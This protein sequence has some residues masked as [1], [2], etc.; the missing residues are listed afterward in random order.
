MKKL[1]EEQKKALRQIRWQMPLTV[2]L[3]CF[4]LLLMTQYYTY[5]DKLDSL[6]G[7]SPENLA[8][9]MRSVVDNNGA[10]YAEY[11]QLKTDL[12]KL[13]SDLASGDTLQNT[14]SD[15]ITSLKT[16][17]GWDAVNGE[18]VLVT[19]TSVSNLYYW[20]LIDITNE[21]FNAGAEAVAINS[22]RITIHTQ[23]T[24]KRKVEQLPPGAMPT[25]EPQEA[26]VHVVGG[27]ELQ[28]PYQIRAIG[29]A[30]TLE[31][32]LNMPGGII[33]QLTT[34]YAAN[35][36]VQRMANLSLPRAIIPAYHYAAVSE[37]SQ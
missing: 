9:I 4:G 29:N 32:A 21:L 35:V 17:T 23:I 34:I 27:Q 28:P 31:T 11:S 18:G 20:D 37:S 12:A 1:S 19:I 5:V 13:E 25:A 16:A 8:K 7:E 33:E 36:K 22:T 3:L 14:I 24:E 15:T 10:L 26:I 6:N 30:A 2:V